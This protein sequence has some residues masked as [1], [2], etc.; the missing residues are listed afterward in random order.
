MHLLQNLT[1]VLLDLAYMASV[2]T[3]STVTN[4]YVHRDILE[5]FANQVRDQA[6]YQILHKYIHTC[7]YAIIYA[8]KLTDSTSNIDLLLLQML[9]SVL[10]I[11]AYTARA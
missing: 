5:D 10:L 2:R 1:T 8:H 4:A 9:T 3:S 11:H 7:K 6:L